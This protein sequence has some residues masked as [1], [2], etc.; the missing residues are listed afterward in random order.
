MYEFQLDSYDALIDLDIPAILAGEQPAFLRE[1][2]L[3]LVCTNGRRDACCARW[4]MPTYMALSAAAERSQLGTE[5]VWQTTHLGGHRLAPNVL[6]F[7]GGFYYGRVQPDQAQAFIADCIRGEVFLEQLRGRSCYPPVVQAAERFL[8]RQTGRSE[9]GAFV[10]LDAAELDSNTWM[11]R[12]REPLNRQLHQLEVAVDVTSIPI[13]QSCGKEKT[14][15]L[16]NY[17]L[18]DYR[19]LAAN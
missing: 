8:Y 16:V 11:V 19:Q 7:P 6:S 17:E 2:P 4:G 9:I 13:R 15:P 3:I 5:A 12:F 10:Y 18:A 14:E 1:R